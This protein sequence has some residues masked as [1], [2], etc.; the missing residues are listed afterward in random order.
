MV[1]KS[2]REGL[3][4][5]TIMLSEREGMLSSMRV[6]SIG[7]PRARHCSP[8]VESLEQA[9][10][11]RYTRRRHPFPLC[12]ARRP[13]GVK[14]RQPA[15][16]RWFRLTQRLEENREENNSDWELRMCFTLPVF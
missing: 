4:Q 11:S 16:L 1:E 6:L 7:H 15:R 3:K 12:M 5:T 10:R 2:E 13:R 14:W 9:E 8:S